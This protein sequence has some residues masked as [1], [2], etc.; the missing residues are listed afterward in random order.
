[1]IEAEWEVWL[2]DGTT[3]NSRDHTWEDVPDGVL[4]VRRWAGGKPKLVSWGE[5]QYGH[6][7][8]LREA[9]YVSDEEFQLVLAEAKAQAVPPSKR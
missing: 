5:G 9:G 4:V 3:R 2:A 1:M 6:P 8:S 7:N